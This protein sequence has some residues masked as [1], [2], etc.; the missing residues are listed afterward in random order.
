MSVLD[1]TR[2]EG[3]LSRHLDDCLE[4]SERD[5][6]LHCLSHHEFAAR[7][8]EMT[9]LNA[10]IEGLSAVP[11]PDSVMAELVLSDLRDQ[12]GLHDSFLERPPKLESTPSPSII[13]FSRPATKK[14]S[15]RLLTAAA[16]LIGLLALAGIYFSKNS[17][18]KANI[19]TVSGE[20]Y[21]ISKSRQVRLM[22]GQSLKKDGTL[23][24]VGPD[25]MATLL[26]ADGTRVEVGG[27]SSVATE[28]DPGKRR[29]FLEIG[30][31][32]SQV[33]KQRDTER[34][35]FYTDDAEA[36][37]VGTVLKLVKKKYETLL[38]VKEG[39]VS[40]K[41]LTGGREIIVNA[42]FYSRVE[43]GNIFVPIPISRLPKSLRD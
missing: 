30:T 16:L 34:L 42:G 23:K 5:E 11:V 4:Q 21:F 9:K 43:P 2:F 1:T 35:L 20:V 24:T 37:V 27:D 19:A 22:A 15:L 36:I 8:L 41:R 40:L 3:L 18:P 29:I 32:R 17:I 10:E 14:Y 28:L 26:L 25:S 38:V 13:S 31:I 12:A 39:S 33:A 6:L 7:F